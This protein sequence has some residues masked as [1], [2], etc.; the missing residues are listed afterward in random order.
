MGKKSR[1]GRQ[2]GKKM[3]ESGDGGGAGASSAA[4]RLR[5]A[6]LP[7]LPPV[8]ESLTKDEFVSFLAHASS[9]GSLT[10]EKCAKMLLEIADDQVA[11]AQ[12]ALTHRP[13][14]L[15]ATWSKYES[16]CKW[17]EWKKADGTG[18]RFDI[19]DKVWAS[20]GENRRLP[21]KVVAR[22]YSED[23]WPP[24]WLAAYQLKITNDCEWEQDRGKLIYAPID[25]VAFA[26]P[27]PDAPSVD[28]EFQRHQLLGW[29]DRANRN[30]WRAA[31]ERSPLRLACFPGSDVAHLALLLRRPSPENDPNWQANPE[32]ETALHVCATYGRLDCAIL[33]LAAG[34]DP[35]LSDFKGDTPV[36]IAMKRGLGLANRWEQESLIYLLTRRANELDAKDKAAGRFG[37]YHDH[38][39]HRGRGPHAHSHGGVPCSSVHVDNHD[40]SHHRGHSHQ[41]GHSHDGVPCSGHHQ[42]HG[43][44]HGH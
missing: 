40:H 36:G 34:G 13:E 7:P 17:K 26:S 29:G 38:H 4:V 44:S 22:W 35:R 41:H 37:G 30:E 33:I 24:A 18:L 43:H 20:M 21:A 14:T 10:E 19:G 6:A 2:K 16:A 27:S 23:S 11:M 8:G 31:G 25:S 15:R 1:R 3:D 32:R 12:V 39:S 28:D 5:G 9:V 42:Q